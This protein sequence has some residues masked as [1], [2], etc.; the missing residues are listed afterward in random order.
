[1]NKKLS[2]IMIISILSLSGCANTYTDT[3][4]QKLAG[5]S[6]NQKR[7]ILAQEC[8]DKINEYQKPDN[9][10]SIEHSK[11]MKEVCEDM[12]GNKITIK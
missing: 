3:L 1:M 5:K 12:T 4:K 8:K 10:E 2:I 9:T 6:D 7:I 11:K